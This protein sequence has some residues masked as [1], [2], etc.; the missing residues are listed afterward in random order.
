MAN[1]FP[2]VA[3]SVLTAAQL[4]GIGEA[5]TAY[6]PTTT[7]FTLG[8]GT[9][10]Y[11]YT[12]VNKL[13]FVKGTITFGSTSAFT[14]TPTFTFPVT[15]TAQYANQNSLGDVFILD[16]GTAGY[17]GL[18]TSESTTVFSLAVGNLF[19]GWTTTTGLSATVPMTW[20]TNDSVRFTL[21]YEAA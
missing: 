14:G 20:T 5:A 17:R 9:A 8:N 1:P 4:N 3:G 10:T 16:S 18:C 12:R 21:I 6:T 13:V 2:F 19:G 15:A 11:A 7:N